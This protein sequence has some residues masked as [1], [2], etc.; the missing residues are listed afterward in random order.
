MIQPILANSSSF[1]L[2]CRVLSRW[3]MTVRWTLAP[4]DSKMEMISNGARS[5]L[6]GWMM[7]GAPAI[8][9]WLKQK[10]W[11]WIAQTNASNVRV[12]YCL[13]LLFN[14]LVYIIKIFQREK[15][16]PQFQTCLFFQSCQNIISPVLVWALAAACRALFSTSIRG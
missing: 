15:F 4:A 2:S 6:P 3:D 12:M 13:N 11:H 16:A 8:I 14:K 7:R 1:S 5:S 10:S 9:E